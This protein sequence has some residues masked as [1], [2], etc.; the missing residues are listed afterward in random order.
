MFGV[1]LESRA[2][3]QR[4]SG[5][6]VL[7]VAAHLA[8]AGLVTATSTATARRPEPIKP[9]LVKLQP[10]APKPVERTVEIVRETRAGDPT[11]A[12]I[13]V[14]RFEAPAIV[15]TKLPE[16]VLGQGTPTVDTLLINSRPGAGGGATGRL[17]LLDLDE[18]P[19]SGEWRGSEL[20]MRM[21][22]SGKPRYPE[23]LRQAG[24]DG[25]VLIRFVVDTTGRI[26]PA[27]VSIVQSTHDLFSR[28]VRD[29]LAQFRF[30]PAETGGRRVTALAEM[31]FEFTISK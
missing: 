15:P 18:K 25:R 4:R 3:R 19:S 20:L 14:P 26:D 12:P 24:I 21:V 28:A 8:I 11:F 7:S 9:T 10:P 6:T 5:G 23:S 31:P 27:S 16:I 17:G 13:E 29:A 2:R 30:R 1:L 22:N